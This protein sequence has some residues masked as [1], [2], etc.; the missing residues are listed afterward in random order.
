[1]DRLGFGGVIEHPFG[2]MPVRLRLLEH[3]RVHFGVFVSLSGNGRLE[4][5]GVEPM[6]SIAPKCPSA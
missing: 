5:L 6:P 2:L 4:V 3:G 1:M